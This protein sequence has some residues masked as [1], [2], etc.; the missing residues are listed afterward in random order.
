MSVCSASVLAT[1]EDLLGHM[2]SV[3]LF[4]DLTT[5]FRR[6]ALV[7]LELHAALAATG[8]AVE[9]PTTLDRATTKVSTTHVLKAVGSHGFLG[10]P[11]LP[12]DVDTLLVGHGFLDRHAG[13]APTER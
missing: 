11:S 8:R 9:L 13:L 5:T 4:D 6:R 10:D 1:P 7:G 2:T 12:I 3:H